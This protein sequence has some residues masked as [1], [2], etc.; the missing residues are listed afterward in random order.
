[1]FW[2]ALA[3]V[4]ANYFGFVHLVGVDGRPIAQHD[5]TP[6]PMFRPSML[7]DRYNLQPD[8]HSLWIPRAAPSGLYW[9]SVG[10]HEF[11]SQERLPAFDANGA[12]LADGVRLP[13]VKVLGSPPPPPQHRLAASLGDIA[14]LLGYD[15]E[16]AG[17]TLRPGQALTLTLYYRSKTAT[18]V[19]YTRFVHVNGPAGLAAGHDSP[20]HEGGNPTWAW[21]PG[22]VVADQS[23][24]TLPADMAP[25]AYR[26]TMGFYN[27]AAGGTRLAARDSHGQPLANDEVVLGELASAQ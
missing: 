10:L 21:V 1:M 8:H 2:Q 13:P 15:L 19:D 20:P 27:R 11:K 6:G 18:A 14:D 17:T 26:L 25:G 7:W 5:Q 4:P 3:P 23:V 9:P 16:P 24:V 22:E 12:E